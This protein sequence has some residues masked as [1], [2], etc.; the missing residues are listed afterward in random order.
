[1]RFVANSA[2]IIS[3]TAPTRSQGGSL[4]AIYPLDH[5]MFR[6]ILPSGRALDLTRDEVQERIKMPVR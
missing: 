1:M 5:G 3:P 2:T 6:V 4:F